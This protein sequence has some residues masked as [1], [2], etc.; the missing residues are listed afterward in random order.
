MC[1]LNLL[2]IFFS[3]YRRK[4]VD[5]LGSCGSWQMRRERVIFGLSSPARVEHAQRFLGVQFI[6]PKCGVRGFAT[7]TFAPNLSRV[8]QNIGTR[9]KVHIIRLTF[10]III[11]RI[12]RKQL[13]LRMRPI[14][15]LTKGVESV[16]NIQFL[17][18]LC[19]ILP[20]VTSG[21]LL[22]RRCFDGNPKFSLMTV[23]TNLWRHGSP[24]FRYHSISLRESQPKINWGMSYH[25]HNVLKSSSLAILLGT[26]VRCIHHFGR[27]IGSFRF[28]NSAYFRHGAVHQPCCIGL[29]CLVCFALARLDVHW[30]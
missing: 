9:S 21:L 8:V 28:P 6:Y 25:V 14:A 23:G 29:A 10:T 22:Q 3:L 1:S 15:L 5:F 18:L 11:V 4:Q 13:L 2:H 12:P 24:L 16:V 20:R 7:G 17:H 30:K 26:P 19:R 27:V